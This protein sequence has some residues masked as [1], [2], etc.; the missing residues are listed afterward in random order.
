MP[1]FLP[2]S[3][4]MALLPMEDNLD[5]NTPKG[6]E[7]LRYEKIMLEKIAEKR[8]VQIVETDKKSDA[9]CDGIIIKNN[10]IVGV[11]ESKC[12][13]MTQEQLFNFG[14]WLVTY[15]KIIHG[16]YLSEMLRVGFFGF[17]YLIPDN[18]I[19]M[20]HITDEKG[21]FKYDFESMETET[22]K[23]INGGTVIRK[24]SFLPLSKSILIYD[25]NS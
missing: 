4:T 24:N 12:R 10:K 11:F 20:W 9:K 5:I 2:A 22:Q 8:N 19:F 1:P 13:N 18:T 16:K 23:T 3:G 14:S 6:Q 17:L 25:G 7:S 15:D 21:R